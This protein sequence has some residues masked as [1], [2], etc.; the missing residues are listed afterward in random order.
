MTWLYRQQGLP[1]LLSTTVPTFWAEIGCTFLFSLKR[2]PCVFNIPGFLGL[3]CEHKN[4][5]APKKKMSF[6]A[7]CED[8]VVHKPPKRVFL[9]QPSPTGS[10]L[11]MVLV[12]MFCAYPRAHGCTAV[13]FPALG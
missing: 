9:G 6:T 12:A 4:L 7:S 13:V 8:E 11:V 10:A 2:T 5:C 1:K 3:I